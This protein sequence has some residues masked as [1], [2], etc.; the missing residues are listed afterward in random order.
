MNRRD[1]LKTGAVAITGLLRPVPATPRERTMRIVFGF[2]GSASMYTN[3]TA[4]GSGITKQNAEIQYEGHIIA[5][6]SERVLRALV[7]KKPVV[8]C[9]TWAGSYDWAR[10][11]VAPR[12][13]TNRHE[14]ESLCGEITASKSAIAAPVPMSGTIHASLL[15]F[16]RHGMTPADLSVLDVS[17]DEAVDK[18][19]IGCEKERDALEQLGWIV[20]AL[21]VDDK[22]GDKKRS[23]QARVISRT[24]RVWQVQNWADYATA[25]EEKMFNELIS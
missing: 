10:E 13:V 5:L 18:D 1:L 14:V 21:V 8:H 9:V 22:D 7:L 19:E 23:M 15:S 25:L 24:G 6:R 4:L 20:N 12:Q 16:V 2:D 11:F 3:Y 17:T